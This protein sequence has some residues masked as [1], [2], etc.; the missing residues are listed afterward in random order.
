MA[1]SPKRQRCLATL[2]LVDGEEKRITLLL[3]YV[4][5][6]APRVNF[7]RTPGWKPTRSPPRMAI[8]DADLRGTT[9]VVA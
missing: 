1:Y 3:Q 5:C 6:L 7:T 4:I 9:G 2:L 8:V